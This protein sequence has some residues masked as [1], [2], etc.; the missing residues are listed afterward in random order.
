MTLF[1]T[2]LFYHNPDR[3][4]D[5]QLLIKSFA[6]FP[7]ESDGFWFD[8]NHL[9]SIPPTERYTFDQPLSKVDSFYFFF[10]KMFEYFVLR[11]EKVSFSSWWDV[12]NLFLKS[13]PDCHFLCLM[14]MTEEYLDKLDRRPVDVG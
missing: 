12:F 9:N 4:R 6:C 10:L 13:F 1:F 11:M 5:V 3:F 2:R 8:E 7:L 14:E